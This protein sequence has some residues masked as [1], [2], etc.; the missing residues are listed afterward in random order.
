MNAATTTAAGRWTEI[1]QAAFAAILAGDTSAVPAMRA[2]QRE[3]LPALGVG[4][5]IEADGV[6][7]RIAR[8]EVATQ[9]GA[10]VRDFEWCTCGN[11][12]PGGVYFVNLRSRLHGFAC[13]SCRA[14][15]QLG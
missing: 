14:I 7:C 13:A 12:Q 9:D 6:P 15:V 5:A 3:L 11:Q 1:E 2:E 4:D 8:R 10:N